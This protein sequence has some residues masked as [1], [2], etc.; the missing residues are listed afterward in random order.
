[1]SLGLCLRILM[2]KNKNNLFLVRIFYVPTMSVAFHHIFLPLE[3][4]GSVFSGV[5]P[6]GSSRLQSSPY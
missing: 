4:L 5:L 6:S 2:I 1:M 3:E